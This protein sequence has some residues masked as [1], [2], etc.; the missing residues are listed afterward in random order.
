[1]R[2]IA[3]IA[4]VL[5]SA[6][7]LADG[8]RTAT[9]TAAF[10]TVYRALESPRCMNCHPAGDAPLQFDDSRPHA[11]NIS[12][13]SLRNG[14]ACATCHHDRNGTRPGQPPGAPNWN[15]PP[16]ETPMVFEGRT[17]AQLCAQLKDP[18]QTRGRDLAA[19][20]AHVDTDPLVQWGW[21]PGPGR[22]PVPVPHDELVRAMRTWADAGAPCPGP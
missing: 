18:V 11:M 1:M 19:L 20:I 15:L 12:R 2:T 4:I 5:A 17:P 6:A 16:A 21:A 13:R 3:A 8:D 10:M 14:L 9:G 22:T 7:V